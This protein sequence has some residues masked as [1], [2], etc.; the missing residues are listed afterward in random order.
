MREH[1]TVHINGQEIPGTLVASQEVER[2]TT[3]LSQPDPAWEYTDQQGH[4]HA[5]TDDDT[6]NHYPTLLRRDE[7]VDCDGSCG[8]VCEGEGYTVPRFYCFVC[9][10]QIE[11]GVTRGP[12]TTTIPGLKYWEVTLHAGWMDVG[13][14]AVSLRMV[15]PGRT[16][17][18]FAEVT[19]TTICSDGTGETE[20]AG[21]SALGTRKNN[22][23]MTTT[24]E[25]ELALA[26]GG[27]LTAGLTPN[28]IAR[29]LVRSG[30]MNPKLPYLKNMET[31]R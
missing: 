17:F 1:V 25:D 8:G 19:N 14:G 4:Y 10:E 7:H 12:H 21:V 3:N 23:P 15:K 11:P 24:V 28:A 18:G 30:W 29:A 31:M 6:M 20:L 27:G 16:F 2:V 13:S 22:Q 26:L 5:Y 9:N